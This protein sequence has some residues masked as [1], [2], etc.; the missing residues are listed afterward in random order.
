MTPAALPLDGR[1]ILVTREVDADGPLEQIVG[2]AGARVV[3][4]SFSRTLP[5]SSPEPLARAVASLS[6][7]DWVA[8]TS[9]RAVAALGNVFGH[10]PRD[11]FPRAIPSD[12]LSWAAV[13][14]ATAEALRS[15]LGREPD[16]I[17]AVS[18]A[19]TLAR[20]LARV[21][22]RRVL[23]PCAADAGSD[24]E[25][26]LRAS[27]ISVD[28]VEAYRVVPEPPARERLLPPNGREAWDVVV[29]TSR[30]AVDVFYDLFPDA[31]LPSASRIA[32]L[33]KS[34]EV[35]VLARGIPTKLIVPSRPSMSELAECIVRELGG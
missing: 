2:R 27:G 29:F 21:G 32:V 5:P 7:Y 25:D 14:P 26:G 23:F 17:S 20:E 31:T 18:D 13:G 4:V 6:S 8:L 24:L 10:V 34:A 16:L 1:T 11:A 19:A 9:A 35:A 30:L 15:S 33:G 28:R 12:G 3:G 22:A